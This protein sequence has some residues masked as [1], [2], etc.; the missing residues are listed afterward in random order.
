MPIAISNISKAPKGQSL[1]RDNL[2]R[3]N[4]TGFTLVEILVSVMILSVGLVSAIFLQVLSIKQGTN[5]DNMT[6]ASLIAESEIER[7][8]TYTKFNE[9]TSAIDDDPT[10]SVNRSGGACQPNETCFVRTTEYH[11]GVPTTRSHTIVIT[12]SWSGATGARNI[13]YES[14]M[15]DLNLGN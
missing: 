1:K 13:V 12:V 9:I 11:S 7:L 2:K 14:V 4:P 10:S 3:G 8:K 15:T 5:A 6:V